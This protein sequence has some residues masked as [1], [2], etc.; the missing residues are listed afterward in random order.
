MTLEVTKEGAEVLA[1]AHQ[2]GDISLSLRRIGENDTP[3]STVT[4]L[5]TDA[6][7]LEVL[8][9]LNKIMQQTKS[10]S[11]VRVYSGTGIQNVPVRN[12]GTVK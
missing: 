2:M 11:T 8:Q 10:S 7:T 5:T 1:L 3:E 4:P 12:L 6:T 9:R